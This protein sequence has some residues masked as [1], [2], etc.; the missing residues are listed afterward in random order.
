MKELIR[1]GTRQSALAVW[2]AK[3][4]GELLQRIY[5]KL[6]VELVHFDTKGDRILE[7]PLA[8]IGGKGLFTAELETAMHERTIDIAV[9]SLKDMPTDLPEGLVLGAI[10]KREDPCD[11]L[12]SPTYKTLDKLPQGA[13]VGTS[14]LRRQ[15]QL[16]HMRPDLQIQTLRGNVQTRLRKLE[17]DHLDAI[18]LASAGLKRLGLADRMTQRLTPEEMIPAVGQGA[19]AVECRSD[20]EE[21]LGILQHIHDEKTYYAVEGERSFLRQLQG[22]CQVPIGVHGTVVD[23][24]LTLKAIIASLDGKTVYEGELSGPCAK[25]T[26][27]GKHLAMAL[28][29]EGG[30][31]IIDALIKE[32]I[33]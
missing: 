3:H 20:D 5:P 13:I 27:L 25:A 33:V 8:A 19:L 23:N 15:A 2:Q 30:K 31:D 32:G 6:Q 9:H 22:G 4:V 21:M 17:E 14:S 29:N 16:L 18:I 7:K 26:L 1:I 10:T 24:Q 12:V 11:A 28:Y